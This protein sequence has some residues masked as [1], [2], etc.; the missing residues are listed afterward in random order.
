V[1]SGMM[2]LISDSATLA[3]FCAGLA[4]ETYITVDTEFLRD[5]T[6]WP[7]LCLIQVAGRDVAAAIDPL[8][9][10]DLAPLK[11][12]LDNPAILKVFHAA[13]QDLEIFYHLMGTIPHP[14]FDTQVAGMVCGFG[15]SV[16]YETLAAKLA[17]AKIDKSFRFTDW[18]NRPLSDKQ[19]HYALSDVTHLRVAY[20]KLA[21]RLEKTGRASWLDEEMAIL[22]DPATYRLD[23]E[24]AWVRLK[25]RNNAPK[26]LNVL[27]EVAAWRETEAQR[28]NLPRNR[29]V[30]DE[31]L[32]EVAA[33]MPRTIA[34]I[35]RSRSIGKGVAEGS[36][37]QA[38][39]DAVERG[40]A[41]PVSEAPTLADRLDVPAGRGP[42]IEL[43]K[44][45]LKLKCETHDVAQKLVATVSDL[46]A[47]A[48]S[49]TA[50][51]PAMHGWRLE[52]FGTDALALKQGR[53]AL[54]VA[55]DAIRMV[56]LET[57]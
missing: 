42:L 47:I 36:V 3:E 10:I 34:D 11:A 23:P 7:Q 51:V 22:T 24:E 9:E 31:S 16:S 8:A 32:I 28:R 56:R 4:H 53:I 2:N 33:L 55:N 38:L 14:L 45:L 37:G 18:S 49:D 57:A 52:V 6:Y 15:D 30:R 19:L 54:T 25:P 41:R 1:Y 5:K 20:E 29:L 50:E 46:E 12:L 43:L 27:R 26:F 21:A 44:V 48:C 17:G 40:L 35:A 13:R 39:L